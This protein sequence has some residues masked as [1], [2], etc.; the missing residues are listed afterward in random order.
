MY[1]ATSLF[2]AVGQ[3][4][5]AILVLFSYPLQVQ[6]CRNCLDKVFHFG[7]AGNKVEDEIVEDEHGADDMTPL[8]H[9]LLTTA[10][11][12]GGFMIAY[13]VDNLEIGASSS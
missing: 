5:I 2:I 10:V 9:T 6:P 12:T 8:K 7:S 4:A 3:L 1:P 13:F 11:V